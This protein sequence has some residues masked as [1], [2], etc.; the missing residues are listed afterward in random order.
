MFPDIFGLTSPPRQLAARLAAAA[1]TSRRHAAMPELMPSQPATILKW[2]TPHAPPTPARPQ[3]RAGIDRIFSPRCL[4]LTARRNDHSHSTI[5]FS[6]ALG[7]MRFTKSTIS[8]ALE[9]L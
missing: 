3:T 1:S 6:I 4:M 7:R 9:P 5:S 2:P 8:A